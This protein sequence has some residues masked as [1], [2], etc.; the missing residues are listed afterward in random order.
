MHQSSSSKWVVPGFARRSRVA[1][2]WIVALNGVSPSG[3][4][5]STAIDPESDA[6]ADAAVDAVV[7]SSADVPDFSGDS[8]DGSGAEDA[9]GTPVCGNGAVEPGEACDDGAANSDV[10]PDA[11]RSG[12]VVA[13][14]GDG[15]RDSGEQCDEPG[16]AFCTASC[17]RVET[18]VCEPCLD[19]DD[20]GGELDGCVALE[21]GE[22]CG[23][24]CDVD[25]ECPDGFAC[26]L[27]NSSAGAPIRHCVPVSGVCVSC[28]DPD[29]DG[30][31]TG[32]DCAGSDCDQT[33]ASIRP[34]A[35]ELCDGVDNDCDGAVDEGNPMQ[36]WWLDLDGDGFGEAGSTRRSDC[37]RLEGFATNDADCNDRNRLVY[38]GAFE[39]CDSVDNDCDGRVDDGAVAT[40]FWPDSDGDGFGSRVLASQRSCTPISGWVTNRTDCDDGRSDVSPG[41]PEICSNLLDDDCDGAPDCDDSACADAVSCV[42]ACVDDRLEQNDEPAAAVDVTTGSLAGL[43]ACA[44]DYDFFAFSLE[45][46]AALQIDVAFT[47][48]EGDIDVF[49]LDNELRVVASSTGVTDT[50]QVVYVADVSGTYYAR[51]FLYSDA[52]SAGSTYSVTFTLP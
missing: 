46:G 6:V 8:V 33:E 34:G 22:N 28:Y 11:C 42:A 38:E 47:H 1:W 27:A 24:D 35:V 16:S 43:T 13:T 14:C 49:V 4:V 21:D 23:L 40:E 37:R 12:C 5:T 52:G 20:C 2:L 26:R 32:V 17:E 44:D 51:V 36:D 31:G 41:D 3:C 9:P 18:D 29:R 48:A 7:D 19:D 39:L 30:F 10:N 50:E 25:A 15:V 45:A